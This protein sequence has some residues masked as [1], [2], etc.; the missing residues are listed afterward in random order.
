MATKPRG[1]S[2]N[3]GGIDMGN[4][5][6]NK[7]LYLELEEIENIIDQNQSILVKSNWEI[8]TKEWE[9]KGVENKI[10]FFRK[11]VQALKEVS[12]NYDLRKDELIINDKKGVYPY[13]FELKKFVRAIKNEYNL[14]IDNEIRK[15]NNYK[16]E[17]SKEINK[18]NKFTNV[19]TE[20]N[21]KKEILKKTI[22]QSQKLYSSILNEKQLKLDIVIN[23]ERANLTKKLIETLSNLAEKE[24]ER[25]KLLSEYEKLLLKKEG[26]ENKIE[27][28]E[29]FR[30]R[31]KEELK[32]R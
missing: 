12:I 24:A 20:T 22:K 31:K 3:I 10:M 25:Q 30:E 32:K 11:K 1:K 2:K 23:S 5:N 15:I 28:E 7:N 17:L 27:I 14:K 8:I 4:F 16:K 21:R 6:N 29:K 13:T 26:F 9:I 19:W 18:E